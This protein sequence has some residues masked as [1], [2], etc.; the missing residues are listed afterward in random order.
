MPPDI[1]HAYADADIG[2]A[3][4]VN[5]YTTSWVQFLNPLGLR[6][7]YTAYFKSDGQ[8]DFAA[9]VVLPDFDETSLATFRERKT[10]SRST[11]ILPRLPA[12]SVRSQGR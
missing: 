2:I 10:V 5:A 1:D 6:D 7:D 11:S 3:D 8:F 4:L 9:G 12:R